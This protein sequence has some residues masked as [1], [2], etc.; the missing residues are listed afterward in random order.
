MIKGQLT[1][2]GTD[3]QV[4]VEMAGNKNVL[5]DDDDARII[6]N[7]LGSKLLGSVPSGI[8]NG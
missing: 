3:V 5:S 1:T 7:F 6:Q 4:V 8:G 2:I